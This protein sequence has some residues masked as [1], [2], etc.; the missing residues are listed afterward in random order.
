MTKVTREFALRFA[1]EWIAAWN[2]HDLE[3]V[4]SHYTDELEMSSPVIVDLVGEPSGTLKGKPAVRA[5]WAKALA[6]LPDLH[7]DLIDAYA[8]AG[9]V[10]VHYKG[11]R[12]M[13]AEVFW[14]DDGGKVFRAAA[15]YLDKRPVTQAQH[16][17]GEV[18]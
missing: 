9:S 12:G 8:G 7:F 15:H 6:R 2:A 11:P 4:L 16:A 14:F 13:S 18:P 5:Y 1:E 10:V 3:R 17:K